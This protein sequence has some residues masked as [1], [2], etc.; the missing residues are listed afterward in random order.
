MS[1]KKAII[2]WDSLGFDLLKTRSM[3]SANCRVGENWKNG[4]LVPFGNIELSPAA[5]VL[6]YGQGVFEGTKAFETSDERV[7]LFRIDKNAKRLAW[8]TERLCIPK[9]DPN[10]FIDAVSETVRDNL[11]F[12]PPNGKG[13]MYVRPIVWGV[14]PSL[15]VGP[16]T[17][18]RFMIYVS[19][20]GPYFKG[21]LEPT[22]LKISEEHHRAAPGAS[23]GVKAIGNYAPGMV[24]SKK[25]K[26]EGFESL[27]VDTAGRLQNKKNLM[28]ELEKMK[29][30]I[31]RE[32]PD[33][34]HETLLVL[35]ATTGQNALNQAKIF[36]ETTDVTGIVLTK[37]D[38]TAKGGIVLA[39]GKELQ[40][41]V[42]FVGLGE[43]MNDLHPFNTEK[44]AYGLFKELIE[45]TA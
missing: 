4:S 25:A 12:V 9:V 23:G 11:D 16:A 29:R 35:D 31:S 6:N 13:S 37:M 3:Y 18:Y 15:G 32:I 44:F 34:P 40:I 19:P 30:V 10:F 27:I 17:D 42:K 20:V 39:I 2:D 38:G 43:T 22:S 21:G 45:Q 8:S 1:L 7:V 28:N 41:P 14:S 24:P 33:A 36:K 26:E 5:V